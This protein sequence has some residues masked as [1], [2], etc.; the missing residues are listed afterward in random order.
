MRVHFTGESVFKPTAAVLQQ[1][2][3]VCV[4]ETGRTVNHVVWGTLCF[5]ITYGEQSAVVLGRA[6]PCQPM[7]KVAKTEKKSAFIFFLFFFS[8][9]HLPPKKQRKTTTTLRWTFVQ[10]DLKETQFCGDIVTY[11]CS[12]KIKAKFIHHF[13]L[14]VL[15]LQHHLECYD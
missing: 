7:S 15:Q 13:P 4:R 5:N 12:F 6:F 14:L 11:S 9:P 2:V 10:L 1:A 8:N 3:C